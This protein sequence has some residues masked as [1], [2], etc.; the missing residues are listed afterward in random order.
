MS[1]TANGIVIAI[2]VVVELFQTD[3]EGGKNPGSTKDFLNWVF[4]AFLGGAG[5]HKTWAGC[6]LFSDIVTKL[7]QAAVLNYCHFWKIITL[8]MTAVEVDF[9]VVNPFF[10]LLIRN[11][12]KS[13]KAALVGWL[14]GRQLSITTHAVMKC[15]LSNTSR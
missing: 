10:F 9:G 11:A 13:C 5:F 4:L 12:V 1:E 14:G 3:K 7:I 8:S 15:V 6:S 2:L